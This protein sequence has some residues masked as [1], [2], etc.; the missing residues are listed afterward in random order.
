MFLFLV[1]FAYWTRTACNRK[2]K[3]IKTICS[4]ESMVDVFANFTKTFEFY[5]VRAAINIV[6]QILP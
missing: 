1:P 5:F 6:Y 3:K 2:R 4:M